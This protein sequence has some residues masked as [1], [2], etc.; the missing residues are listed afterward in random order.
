MAVVV[1]VVAAL[2]VAFG[3]T[4]AA[5]TTA[6]KIQAASAGPSTFRSQSAL[7]SQALP[8]TLE[9]VIQRS[10]KSASPVDAARPSA[11]GE[12]LVKVKRAFYEAVLARLMLDQAIQDRDYFDELIK[13]NQ[14]RFGEGVIAENDLIKV[15]IERWKCEMDVTDAQ[16]KVRQAGIKVLELIG[17]SDFTGAAVP[18]AGDLTSTPITAEPAALK[19]RGHLSAEVESAYAAYETASEQIGLFKLRLLEQV[20]ESRAIAQVLYQEGEGE[21]TPLLDAQRT[22]ADVRGRYFRTLFALQC[23]LL[24]LERAAGKEIKQ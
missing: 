8:L 6:Q 15:R 19:E 23:S 11:A 16:L 3:L 14:A 20:D 24:K 2:V 21:L 7:S 18:V 1:I 22:R 13:I 4:P 10:L 12:K 17:E 9:R 5:A